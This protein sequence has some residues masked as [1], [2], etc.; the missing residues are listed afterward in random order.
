[1][2]SA[3]DSAITQAGLRRRVDVICSEQLKPLDVVG[4]SWP[5]RLSNIAWQP[6]SVLLG[7]GTSF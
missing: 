4:L 7:G 6:G 5:T 2:V 3:E 1:M